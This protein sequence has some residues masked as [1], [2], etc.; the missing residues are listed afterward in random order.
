[1]GSNEKQIPIPD[2]QTWVTGEYLL[3]YIFD[4]ETIEIITVR[5]GRMS[6]PIINADIDD[7]LEVDANKIAEE[8]NKFT[9]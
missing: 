6:P 1:M 5:S 2:A 4:G 9:R 8:S 3:D 7:K